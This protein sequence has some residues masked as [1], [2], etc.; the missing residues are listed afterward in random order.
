M[1]KILI[2]VTLLCTFISANVAQK[3][4]TDEE[5]AWFGVFNQ[6]RIS[7]R[8][9]IWHD[10]HFR[11]K[12]DFV[13]APSQF[14]FRIGPMI[15]L[16]DDVRVTLGY[17]FINHFPGDN[18]KNISQPEHRPF[19]Q[20]QWFSHYHKTRLMQWI[21]LEER[22]RR[23]ILNDDS[24][25]EGYN[26]NYRVRYNFAWFIPLTKKGLGPHSWQLLLNDELMVNFGDEVVYNYFDQNRL[27]AGFVYQFTKTS[28][29]QFGYMNLF[30][31]LSTG[32]RYRR[33]HTVRVFYFHNFDLRK[34][35]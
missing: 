15:Y 23:K 9:G 2:T 17:N 18:H 33:Q 21:R 32:N 20:I 26:F 6:V 24:L 31:Q 35:K 28:S 14:L 8:L 13:K 12:D 27:F 1:L 7:Q 19:Q 34:P 29:I 25:A 3:T 30:Q 5:Q 4:Y 16:G 22:F 11:L 10:T